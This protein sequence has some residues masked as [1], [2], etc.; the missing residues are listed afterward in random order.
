LLDANGDG[1]ISIEEWESLAWSD[2]IKNVKKKTDEKHERLV[3]AVQG[4]WK[5]RMVHSQGGYSSLLLH[6]S[7]SAT[8]KDYVNRASLDLEAEDKIKGTLGDVPLHP[9]LSFFYCGRWDLTTGIHPP[10]P[11]PVILPNL[12]FSFFAQLLKRSDIAS[13]NDGFSAAL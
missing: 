6:P 9:D 3:K 13:G 4:S 11:L 8:K 12:T 10:P 2:L 7:K 5:V 1:K